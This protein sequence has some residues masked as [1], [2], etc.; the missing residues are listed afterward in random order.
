MKDKCDKSEWRVMVNSI[1]AFEMPYVNTSKPGNYRLR[2]GD[3]LH[4]VIPSGNILL[5]QDLVLQ[6]KDFLENSIILAGQYTLFG[7][8]IFTFNSEQCCLGPCHFIFQSKDFDESNAHNSVRC[9]KTGVTNTVLIESDVTIAS[10][11][12]P[13]NALSV[14][15]IPSHLLGTIDTWTT[16]LASAA[17]QNYNVIHLT[18]IQTP[19]ESGS[20]YSL[21]EHEKISPCLLPSHL[22]NAKDTE[23]KMSN[24]TVQF[25][26]K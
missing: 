24:E 10:K 14:L 16:A 9:K 22:K 13:G 8:L 3:I 20:C 25:F 23:S 1:G 4:L 11:E 17:Y 12:I 2:K 15:T 19:G 7:D 26:K 21:A 5:E 6:I 18:P